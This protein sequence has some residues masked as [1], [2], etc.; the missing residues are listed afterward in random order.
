MQFLSK[1]SANLKSGKMLW[2]VIFLPAFHKSWHHCLTIFATKFTDG[3]EASGSLPVYGTAT[4]IYHI[5]QS[6]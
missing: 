6:A 5:I 3:A 4:K 2:A 1:S